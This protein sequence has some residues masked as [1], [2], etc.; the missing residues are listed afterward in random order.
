MGKVAKRVVV[1]VTSG[2]MSKE[3]LID[4]LKAGRFLPDIGENFKVNTT[5]LSLKNIEPSEAILTG[6]NTEV[7][8]VEGAFNGKKS[9]SIG[10]GSSVFEFINRDLIGNKQELILEIL[11]NKL[12]DKTIPAPSVVFLIGPPSTSKTEILRAV[13]KAA[14]SWN[15]DVE[16][17]TGP[18]L[19]EKYV[20]KT[21][22]VIEELKNKVSSEF[23]LLIDEVD[24]LVGTRESRNSYMHLLEAVTSMNLLLD[25]VIEQ[26]GIAI[27]ASNASEVNIDPAILNRSLV[28]RRGTASEEK[29]N[30]SVDIFGK[31]FGLSKEDIRQLKE[32]KLG[33][34]RTVKV[35]AQMM[36]CGIELERA[37]VLKESEKREVFTRGKYIR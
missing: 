27:L 28:I 36:A 34:F 32:K 21:A 37:M 15:K 23:V 7:Q 24:S 11:D 31:K 9:S 16:Y 30:M 33:S 4:E 18:G 3:S 10:D 20:G 17:H 29:V 5:E 25:S 2:I 19:T 22:E 6:E 14:E 1:E 35:V 8:L 13:K 26:Q 12:H